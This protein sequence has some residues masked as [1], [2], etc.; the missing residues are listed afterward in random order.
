[1]VPIWVP[2]GLLALV[3]AVFL[4]RGA[5]FAD[6]PNDTPVTLFGPRIACTGSR[7]CRTTYNGTRKRN[8]TGITLQSTTS[9][10]QVLNIISY[11][12]LHTYGGSSMGIH[13]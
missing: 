6:V 7:W 4:W 5:V 11:R 10:Y 2:M 3:S 1:M 13:S 12:Y 9:L 8:P